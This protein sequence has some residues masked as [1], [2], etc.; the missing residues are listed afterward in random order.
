MTSAEEIPGLVAELKP[1]LIQLRQIL[2]EPVADATKGSTQHHK[3]TGRRRPG[4][5][6]ARADWWAQQ[7]SEA[8]QARSLKITWVAYSL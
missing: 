3:V 5:L 1:L 2:A 4:T 7:G 6:R 8:T